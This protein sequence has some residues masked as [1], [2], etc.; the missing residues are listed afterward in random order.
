MDDWGLKAGIDYNEQDVE[1]GDL[2]DGMPADD[3]VK[4]RKYDF[5]VPHQSRRDGAKVFVQSQFYAGD[6]GS[7]SH[8]VVDQTD[9][10]RTVTLRKFPQAVFIEYLD[11]AGYYSSLNGDLRKMLSKPTTKDSLTATPP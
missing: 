8:K 2:L 6:S 11:G 10:S 7:V 4:K 9:S 1:I 5:I 3:K